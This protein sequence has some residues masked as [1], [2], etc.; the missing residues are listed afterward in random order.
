M[1]FLLFLLFYCLNF[2][3]IYLSRFCMSIPEECDNIRKITEVDE[4]ITKPPIKRQLSSNTKD[5]LYKAMK[6]TSSES[7]QRIHKLFHQQGDT[8]VSIWSGWLA[9]M[10]SRLV[11]DT[12]QSHEEH[13]VFSTTSW[14]E[15]RIDEEGELG[16]KIKSSIL[17]PTQVSFSILSYFSEVFGHTFEHLPQL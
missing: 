1:F 9:S 14:E 16:E 13:F 6:K 17:V 8:A 4:K 7:L 15:V 5:T 12:L 3:A 11:K 10:V 2:R